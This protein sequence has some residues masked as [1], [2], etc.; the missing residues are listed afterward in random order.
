MGRNKDVL[1]RDPGDVCEHAQIRK[2]IFAEFRERIQSYADALTFLQEKLS[3]MSISF[4]E[5]RNIEWSECAD[6]IAS[7]ITLSEYLKKFHEKTERPVNPSSVVIPFH[8][9]FVVA[10]KKATRQ[11]KQVSRL[12][13]EQ[14]EVIESDLSLLTGQQELRNKLEELCKACKDVV[15]ETRFLLHQTRFQ[16]KAMS[17]S[18]ILHR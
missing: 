14:Y 3:N 16:E 2:M 10:L 8:L 12:L 13:N 17:S 5:Q 9:P 11:V 15:L 1:F 18:I 4:G 6:M 7:V